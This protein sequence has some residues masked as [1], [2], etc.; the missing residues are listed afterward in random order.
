DRAT[1][2]VVGTHS[3]TTPVNLRAG[4]TA[5]LIGKSRTMPARVVDAKTTDKELRGKYLERENIEAIEYSESHTW[6]AAPYTREPFVRL[7]AALGANRA[8]GSI[9]NLPNEPHRL[10]KRW[11]VSPGSSRLPR[12]LVKSP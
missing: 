5:D 8:A 9:K 2:E 1:G 3:F 6:H 10:L 7:V 12:R 11:P 4:K